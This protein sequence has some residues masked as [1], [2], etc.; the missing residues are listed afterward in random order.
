M[1]NFIKIGETVIDKNIIESVSPILRKHS[2]RNTYCDYFEINTNTDNTYIISKVSEFTTLE[3][4][5]QRL[6]DQLL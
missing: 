2:T 3:K 1:S 6:I 5:R 4:E